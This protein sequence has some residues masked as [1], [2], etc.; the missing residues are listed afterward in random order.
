MSPATSRSPAQVMAT[1]VRI[2][3]SSTRTTYVCVRNARVGAPVAF[4]PL[5]GCIEP[6]TQPARACPFT[7]PRVSQVRKAEADKCKQIPGSNATMEIRLTDVEAMVEIAIRTLY[8]CYIF[9]ITEPKECRG[10]L[11]GG[12]LGERPREA[13]LANTF[14][15]ENRYVSKTEQLETG[16][17]AMFYLDG[18]GPDVLTTSVITE[19]GFAATKTTDSSPGDC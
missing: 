10:F 16:Y 2:G 9:R 7:C 12:R 15:P 11:S 17:R 4:I 14:L 18:S 19:L 1:L 13:F 8:S 5:P 3:K 6:A